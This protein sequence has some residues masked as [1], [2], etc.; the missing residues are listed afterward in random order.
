MKKSRTVTNK[1]IANDLRK[2]C[3]KHK[4][5]SGMLIFEKRQQIDPI[6][7][8]TDYVGYGV[9]VDRR[10]KVRNSLTR[11]DDA[12]SQLERN[13]STELLDFALCAPY[14]KRKPSNSVVI[15]GC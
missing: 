4:L 10:K 14:T 15:S 6:I 9:D 1:A 5:D 13:E 8:H 3:E 7:T 12:G 11:L 2:L